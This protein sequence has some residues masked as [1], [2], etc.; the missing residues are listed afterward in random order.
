MSAHQPKPISSGTR[1]SLSAGHKTCVLIVDDKKV[2]RDSVREV[3]KLFPDLDVIGEAESGEQ[4]I[5]F[6]NESKPNLV[7]MDI[8]LPGMNG[9]ECTRMLK[10][11]HPEVAVFVITSNNAENYRAAAIEAG[12]SEYIPK[13]QI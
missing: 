12:A 8:N 7:L 13:S 5:E 1:S 9:L 2:S 6:V 4:A 3:L 10:S 11:Q